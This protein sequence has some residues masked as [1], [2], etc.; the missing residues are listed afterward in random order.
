MPQREERVIALYPGPAGERP[1]AGLYLGHDLRRRP[2]SGWPFFC[3]NF[4]ASL[5]GRIAVSA[6]GEPGQDVP[7]AIA[8]DRDWRLF[9]ELAAQA[10]LIL[11]SGRYARQLADGRAQAILQIERPAFADLAAWRTAQGLAR[12][13]DLAILSRGLEFDLSPELAA[14]FGAVLAI[15]GQ[16]APAGRR[17]ALAAQGA[18]IV[19]AGE[20][21][22]EAGRLAEVIAGRGYGLVFSAAGAEVLHM[23]VA[24]GL[25]NRLYLTLAHRLLAGTDY[26]TLAEGPLLEPAASLTLYSAYL[27]PAGLDGAGQLFLAYDARPGGAEP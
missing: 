14:S 16:S 9:Q 15:T 20:D 18:Q 22:V 11:T 19:L 8:N 4:V 13:P 17:A 1:L 25:L 10:D 5:D 24:G 3:S 27:D 26:S 7:P 2:R 12:R 23:L 21:G 6:P